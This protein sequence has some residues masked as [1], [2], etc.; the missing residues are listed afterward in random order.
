MIIFDV[1][2]YLESYQLIYPALSQVIS[3][4]DRSL[5]Y[6]QPGGLYTHPE[7]R[8]MEY[9]VEELVSG[10]GLVYKAKK[11][12]FTLEITLEGVQL[13]SPLDEGGAFNLTIG[14]FILTDESYKRGICQDRAEPIKTVQFYIPVK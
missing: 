1:L 4:L 9:R 12:F 14:R 7:C 5:P 11:G 8:D 2:D 10:P 6:K 13:I 3:V